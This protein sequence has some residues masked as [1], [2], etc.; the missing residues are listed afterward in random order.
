MDDAYKASFDP[1]FAELAE[2]YSVSLFSDILSCYFGNSMLTLMD[3]MHPNDQGVLA[4]AR[5]LLPQ[6]RELVQATSG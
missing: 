6:V 2:Q 3:G 4:I 1:I 5:G